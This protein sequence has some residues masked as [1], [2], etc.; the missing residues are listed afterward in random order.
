MSW[1]RRIGKAQSLFFTGCEG[2]G[3]EVRHLGDLV[4][5]IGIKK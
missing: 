3:M 1:R 5:L 4:Y 2:A